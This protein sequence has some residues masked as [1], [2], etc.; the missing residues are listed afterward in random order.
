MPFC[1]NRP[2]TFINWYGAVFYCNALSLIDGLTPA[3]VHDEDYWVSSNYPNSLYNTEGWRLPTE[4]EWEYVAQYNDGRP[5]PTG[6]STPGAGV[7]GN[8]GN[9]L[10]RS[11]DVGQYPQGVNALGIHDL[12]GNV[13]EWC[14]DWQGSYRSGSQSNP[15]GHD[16]HDAIAKSVRGG[17]WGSDA[18]ELRCIQRFSQ[19]PRYTRDGLGFRIVRSVSTAP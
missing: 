13:W 3:Y 15:L 11:A 4:S 16:A 10:G 18:D 6:T 14:N 9:I 7:E 12:C 1:E 5:Y 19:R 17:S 8:F 2:A